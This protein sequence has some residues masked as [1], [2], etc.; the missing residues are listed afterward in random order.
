MKKG[1]EIISTVLCIAFC[2]GSGITANAVEARYLACPDFNCPGR[3]IEREYDTRN[4][5][6]ETRPCGMHPFCTEQLVWT[7]H[8]MKNQCNECGFVKGPAWTNKDN[9]RWICSSQMKEQ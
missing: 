3:I 4:G 2:V 9:Y 8:Y 1:N 7:I 6:G 5:Y